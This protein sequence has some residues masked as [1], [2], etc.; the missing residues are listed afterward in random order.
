MYF[1]LV[2]IQREH[3]R[4]EVGCSPWIVV[5]R[6]QRREVDAED[7]GAELAKEVQRKPRHTE[8]HKRTRFVLEETGCSP[9]VA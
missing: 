2:D 9:P 3:L 7:T 1:P 8:T 5:G 4:R 6:K